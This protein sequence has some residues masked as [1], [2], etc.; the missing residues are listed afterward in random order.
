[1]QMAPALAV[2]NRQRRNTLLTGGKKNWD[3]G[4]FKT[5][6]SPERRMTMHRVISSALIVVLFVSLVGTLYG[7]NVSFETAVSYPVDTFPISVA[8]GDFNGD[9][10]R[11]R[12]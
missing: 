9:H 4:V 5:F 12:Q 3:V 10:V 1:M 11:R 2:T 8:V 6:R 7:Q